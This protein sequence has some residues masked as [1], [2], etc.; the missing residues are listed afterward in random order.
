MNKKVHIFMDENRGASVLEVLLAMAIVALAAPFVYSQIARTNHMIHDVAIARKIIASRE[1]VLNFIRINHDVWP[2]V[3]QIRLSEEDLEQVSDS[4]IAGFIDKYNNAGAS[5]TDV[6]LAFDL[7][8]TDLRVNQIAK[9]IGTDAAV[10][11]DDGIAYGNTWAVMAPDFAVGNLIYRI[12]RD[13]TGQDT[14]KYLHRGT[15]G[16]DNLNVMER[17]FSMGGHSVY[18]VATVTASSLGATDV[19]TAFVSSPDVSATSVYFSSGANVDGQDVKIGNLR[20][21]GDVNGF[22]SIL[23]DN[24]N[25]GR[26]YSTNGRILSDR[27]T[28]TGSINVG[29][30]LVLRSSSTKTVSGFTGIT[31]N[32]VVV[33]YIAA[34]EM[35]F[36]NNFGLTVSGELL[37]ST[38][39]PLKLGS[40]S[41]P[42]TKPPQFVEF[43]VSRTSRPAA[44]IKEEFAPLMMSGWKSIMPI[45]K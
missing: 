16:D 6:Y 45:K 29:N 31:A 37:M 34:S 20:V 19:S 18:D 22:R 23:A 17:D 12:S 10:V 27:A 41:F 5:V 24:V 3:A 42:S 36:Y 7:N 4:A 33:P 21:S 40:W 1:D 14:S 32:S 38:N 15:S 26:G 8:D 44:P 2:E 43:A 30:N 25:G 11:G 39:A 13:V 28:I 35:I 9:H